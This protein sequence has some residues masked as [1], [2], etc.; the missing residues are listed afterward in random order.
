[1]AVGKIN[2]E[3]NKS[4]EDFICKG[5]SSAIEEKKEEISNEEIRI[6]LRCPRDLIEKLDQK[7]KEKVGRLSRN[8]AI[9]EILNDHLI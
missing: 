9:I 7:R 4:V 3:A 2:R 5:G 6:T 8:Q 1:M